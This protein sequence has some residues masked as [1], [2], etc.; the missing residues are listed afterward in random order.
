MKELII[1]LIKRELELTNGCTD[2]G[3]IAMTTA[4]AVKELGE[5]PEKIHVVASPNDYKHAVAVGIPGTDERGLIQSAA[6]GCFLSDYTDDGLAILSNVTGEITEKAKSIADSGNI[7]GECKWDSPDLLYF[8][9]TVS[10]G[11]N[12]AYAITQGDYSNIYETALNGVVTNHNKMEQKE[13]V[14]ELLNYR[15]TDLIEE[16]IKM[17]LEDLNFLMDAL[18]V[19]V[20]LIKYLREINTFGD[21]L[22]MYKVLDGDTFPYNAI[23]RAKEYT[24]LGALGRMS[25]VKVPIMG[26]AGSGNH[27]ITNFLGPYA[28]AEILGKSD[29]ELARACAINSLFTIFI[30]GHLKRMTAVCGCSL[31]PSTGT[32]AST[33]YLMGGNMD[34]MIAAVNTSISVSAGMICDGAKESCAYK[35]STATATA[36]EY[37]YLQMSGQLGTHKGTGII[38]EEIDE[39]LYNLDILNR[40]MEKTDEEVIKMIVEHQRK[41]GKA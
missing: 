10:K 20:D 18:K 40:S 38:S 13:K 21:R 26:I 36:I 28:V 9:V 8:K 22:N 2:P 35:L 39:T 31:A 15:I 29:L 6:L 27:G 12:I 32:A 5:I 34:D 4:M 25:G 16:V 7:T 33:V 41:L 3:S 37:A 1:R 19:N 11:D 17:N 14:R 24:T 30:K 23:K